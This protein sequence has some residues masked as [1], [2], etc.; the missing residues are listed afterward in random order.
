MKYRRLTGVQTLRIFSNPFQMLVYCKDDRLIV[1]DP[2]PIIL[3]SGSKGFMRRWMLD[4]II[5]SENRA[6][7][8]DVGP[9]F[10]SDVREW[11]RKNNFANPI[12]V[13][14]EVNVDAG[15]SCM[16]D[17]S[18]ARNIM[19]TDIMR[20]HSQNAASLFKNGHPE[21]EIEMPEHYTRENQQLFDSE[22][23]DRSFIPVEKRNYQFDIYEVSP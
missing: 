18:K 16:K 13:D 23:A 15:I 4:A 8:I 10:F 17:I 7:I 11:F 5:R 22:G 1:K 14:I 19:D 21:F 9:T 20:S 6:S 2:D 12:A 3:E